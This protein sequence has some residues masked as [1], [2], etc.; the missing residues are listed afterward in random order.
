MVYSCEE[1]K[2]QLS[3]LTQAQQEDP[4]AYGA[5]SNFR[6]RILPVLGTM[7]ALVGISTAAHVLCELAGK[8]FSP[9]KIE[10][11]SHGFAHK[12]HNRLVRHEARE[13]GNTGDNPETEA[14]IADQIEVTF[15]LE[16]VWR[17]RSAYAYE[18]NRGTTRN[19]MFTR[20]DRS[21]PALPY[22]LVLL[23]DQEVK[24]HDAQTK[25]TGSLPL[26]LLSVTRTTSNASSTSESDASFEVVTPTDYNAQ[27][28]A[29]LNVTRASGP[30][31]AS[32]LPSNRSNKRQMHESLQRQ[33][34]TVATLKEV[35]A[36]L[37]ALEQLWLSRRV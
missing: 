5:V 15:L 7:P 20:F 22:N 28:P 2:A 34:P 33:A 11:V 16:E 30:S 12:T 18:R 3:E 6:I 26:S 36:K 14:P 8:V 23:T 21:K 24:W 37:A 29:L 35:Q 1:P 9:R 32:P 4:S 25:Q 17:M 27:E 13:F 19:L 10:A 31:A